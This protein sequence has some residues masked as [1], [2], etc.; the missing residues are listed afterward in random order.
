[1]GVLEQLGVGIFV[2]GVSAGHAAEFLFGEIVAEGQLFV[3][4]VVLGELV[5]GEEILLRLAGGGEMLD[6]ILAAIFDFGFGLCGLIL[7]T[8][9]V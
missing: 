8:Q 6:T 2:F 1:V 7:A 3:E 4:D 5:N 9:K